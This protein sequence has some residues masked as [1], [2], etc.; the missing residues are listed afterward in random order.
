MY[1][2][3]VAHSNTCDFVELYS[4]IVFRACFGA[5]RAGGR[6]GSGDVHQTCLGGNTA[7]E[8]ESDLECRVDSSG[9]ETSTRRATPPSENTHF[10]EKYSRSKAGSYLRLI[11]FVCHSTVGSR[12]KKKKKPTRVV[13]L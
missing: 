1:S 11:D 8:C 10:T 9:T 2:C 13:E 6:H 12:E 5:G 4:C 3:S 7:L